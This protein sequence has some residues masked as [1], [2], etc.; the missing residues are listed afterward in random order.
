MEQQEEVIRVRI[1]EKGEVLGIVTAMLG[2]GRVEVKCEDGFTR[3]CR[4]AGKIKRK[5]WIRVGHIVLIKPWSVQTN[6]RGDVIWS[7]SKAQVI[8]LKNKGFLKNLPEASF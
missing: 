7:Y 5:F 3:V 6:E 2:G 8:W 1:P 4:I